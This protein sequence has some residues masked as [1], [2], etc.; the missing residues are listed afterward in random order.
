MIANRQDLKAAISEA[1]AA[2]QIVDVHTHIFPAQFHNMLLWGIDE[3]V[4][5]HYLVAEYFRYST[6]D[7]AEFYALPKT[8]QADLIWQ[9]LFLDRSPVSEAQ[10]GVL[11]ALRILG[12]PIQNSLQ[13][14]RDYFNSLTLEE[15]IDNVFSLS[16]IK[17]VVMTNDPFD[18]VERA[19]WEKTPNQDPRFRASLRIDP[20][21]VDYPSARAILRNLGYDVG[22]ELDNLTAAEIRR[23][24]RDW[25]TKIEALYLAASLPPDFA[26]ENTHAGEMV[27]KCILPVCEELDIPFAPM[28]GVKK[29]INKGLGLAGDSVGKMDI[30]VLEYL[31]TEYPNNKFFV[32]LLSRENQHELAITARKYGNLMIFGCWWFLNNPSLVREITLMR[33]ETLG[34]SFIPQHSDARVLE[35]LIY[36]WN[37]SKQVIASALEEKYG[38]ALENGWQLTREH[39]ARDVAALFETNFADFLRK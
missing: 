20:L 21:L 9:T 27:E 14:Y 19:F 5:Y 34:L 30:R 10:R 12:L 32:T 3:I 25:I 7:C 2:V 24:L 15:H 38:Y 31:C 23:F 33:L 4:T 22:E 28:I 29:L 26:I 18:R 13:P 37:H 6:L 11:T 35:H 17:E 1:M 39:I 36:K 16:G 8:K